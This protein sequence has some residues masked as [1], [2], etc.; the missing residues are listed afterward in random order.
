M[1]IYSVKNRYRI[2][3][4]KIINLS[5]DFFVTRQVTDWF[6]QKTFMTPPMVQCVTHWFYILGVRV[7]F[8][9]RSQIF[10][11]DLSNLRVCINININK[12]NISIWKVHAVYIFYKYKSLIDI[13]GSGEFMEYSL[14]ESYLCIVIP[15]HYQFSLVWFMLIIHF[16]VYF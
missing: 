5:V 16:S 10:I 13:I 2:R 12:Y 7:R 9:M 1:R 6:Y 8:S 14:Y 15:I 11:C 4:Y 3:F